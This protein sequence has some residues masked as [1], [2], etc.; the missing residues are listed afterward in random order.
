MTH[1]LSAPAAGSEPAAVRHLRLV[2]EPAPHGELAA[3]GKPL[4]GYV[5]LVP[6]GLDPADLLAEGAD[7]T[8]LQRAPHTVGPPDTP[9]DRGPVRIDVERRVAQVDGRELDLT[10]LEFEL[11]AHLVAHPRRVHSRESLVTTVWGYHHIGDGRTVDV[12]VARLRRKLGGA[13]RHRIVTVR[14]MGYK[15]EPIEP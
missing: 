9:P 8:T 4:V 2:R 5:V 14:R 3:D 12:H 10:F 7:A 1:S 15:Y 13:H 6:P 11:L